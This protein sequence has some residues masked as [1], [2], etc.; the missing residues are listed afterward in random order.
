MKKIVF[1]ILILI[2]SFDIFA[3][4]NEHFNFVPTFNLK[5]SSNFYRLY[6]REYLSENI[7]IDSVF[8]KR[9]ATFRINEYDEWFIKEDTTWTLFFNKDGISNY[10]NIFGNTSTIL[11][12]EKTKLT[13]NNSPIYHVF[14]KPLNENCIIN[15]GCDY[16][17][18]P[19]DGF[20]IL[21]YFDSYLIRA[22]VIPCFRDYIKSDRYI[23]INS[24]PFW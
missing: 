7:F 8:E 14:F 11:C 1:I 24:I 16:Y 10:I 21:Q 20:I 19:K 13:C 6:Y 17:F 22:D 18:T 4:I 2:Y 3:Q 5:D 12:F 15:D 9:G 23:Y